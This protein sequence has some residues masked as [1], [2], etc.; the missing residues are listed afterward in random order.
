M[1]KLVLFATALVVASGASAYAQSEHHTSKHHR[2][3]SSHAS[4]QND[5]PGYQP[6]MIAPQPHEFYGGADTGYGL[7]DEPS[8]EGRSGGG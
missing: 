3:M 1:K 6:A 7:M 8:V 5:Q 2:L 4:M